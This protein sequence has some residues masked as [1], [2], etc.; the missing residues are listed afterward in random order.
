MPPPTKIF[1][2]RHVNQN[3][4]SGHLLGGGA[5]LTSVTPAVIGRPSRNAADL[6]FVE[7]SATN[8]G[9]MYRKVWTGRA[10]PHRQ[11]TMIQRSVASAKCRLL[12]VAY[13]CHVNHESTPSHFS[14]TN[15]ARSADATYLPYTQR[16]IDLTPHVFRRLTMTYYRC[17][18]NEWW[19][20][21][22]DLNLTS[23]VEL[24]H[25][26]LVQQSFAV[27]AHL[28]SQSCSDMHKTVHSIGG[29]ARGAEGAVAPPH[30]QTRGQTVSNAPP[31]SQT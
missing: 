14:F 19:T 3:T 26:K 8:V 9:D 1:C 28:Y 11:L 29:G 22:L 31:I 7:M 10:A 15:I 20:T 6:E 16:R 12:N 21:D 23:V 30:L 2:R 27:I 13:R 4:P 17:D 25:S 24:V 18:N 5:W